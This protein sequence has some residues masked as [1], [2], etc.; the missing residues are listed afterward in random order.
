M[1]STILQI[2]KRIFF[3]KIKKRIKTERKGGAQKGWSGRAPLLSHA[4]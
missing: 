2:N 4:V 3:P 1:L